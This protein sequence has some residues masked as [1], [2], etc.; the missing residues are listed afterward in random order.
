MHNHFVCAKRTPRSP[1]SF[2][3]NTT[4]RQR[5]WF[6][7]IS[8]L[9]ADFYEDKFLTSGSKWKCHKVFLSRRSPGSLRQTS[10]HLRCPTSYDNKSLIRTH[11]PFFFLLSRQDAHNGTSR[12][13]RIIAMKL[14]VGLSCFRSCRKVIFLSDRYHPASWTRNRQGLTLSDSGFH[15]EMTIGLSVNWQAKSVYEVVFANILSVRSSVRLSTRIE[16][17]LTAHLNVLN[18]KGHLGKCW[19]LSR[20]YRPWKVP[21]L[22]SLY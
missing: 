5:E 13:K 3:K 10:C 21:S 19:F 1:F 2:E 14:S 11:A 8:D 17:C 20:L 16:L 7:T 22:S 12:S 6:W 18:S 4:T 9:S 15:Q